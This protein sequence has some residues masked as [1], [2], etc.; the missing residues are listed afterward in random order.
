MLILPNEWILDYLTPGANK[1]HVSEAFVAACR[2]QKH[3]YLIRRTS[4]FSEKLFRY[5]KLYPLNQ[6]IKRFVSMTLRDFTMVQ[7]VDEREIIAEIPDLNT[8]P[9][10]D[11]Y[12]AEV[13]Y[14]FSQAV[15]ISTDA[16]LVEQVTHLNLKAVLFQDDINAALQRAEELIQA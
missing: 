10:D 15:L 8:I 9:K 16:F 2:E 1:P 3:R 14:S 13:L 5:S 7:L 4:S 12:L 6:G 11:R